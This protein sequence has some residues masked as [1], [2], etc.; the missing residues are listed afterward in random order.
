MTIP[1]IH[2]AI[3][4]KRAELL[5]LVKDQRQSP[6]HLRDVVDPV[7]YQLNIEIDQLKVALYRANGGKE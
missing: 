3:D 6:P 2:Q 5:Q 1:E 7:I 4:A